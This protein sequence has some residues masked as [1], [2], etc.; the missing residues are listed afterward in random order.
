MKKLKDNLANARKMLEDAQGDSQARQGV[1]CSPPI[2]RD[3]IVLSKSELTEPRDQRVLRPSASGP[4]RRCQQPAPGREV[5][6]HHLPWRPGQRHRFRPGLAHS[7]RRRRQ[8]TLDDRNNWECQPLLGLPHAAQA[9]PGIELP[10]VPSPG[11]R[12]VAGGEQDRDRA[13]QKVDTPG[14][15]WCAATTWCG[16]TAASAAMRSPASRTAARSGPTCAWNRP[17]PWRP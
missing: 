14:P 7:Q 13:D 9:L 4:V 5:R 12:P 6:L 3:V 2:C 11:H 15:R 16:R 17:R 8:E 10:E 1:D